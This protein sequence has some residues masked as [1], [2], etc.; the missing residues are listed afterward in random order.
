MRL[1]FVT[2]LQHYLGILRWRFE[3]TTYANG[4]IQLLVIVSYFGDQ[5]EG[6]SDHTVINYMEI[7][8][9]VINSDRYES[10][11]DVTHDPRT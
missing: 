5:H 3:Q 10:F 11:R 2:P 9:A 4:P 8:I 6:C 7:R 1:D